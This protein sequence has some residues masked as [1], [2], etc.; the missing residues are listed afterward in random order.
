MKQTSLFL[1]IVIICFFT[2]L[3]LSNYAQI[4]N[5]GFES[6]SYPSPPS[7]WHA[8]TGLYGSVTQNSPGHDNSTNAVA[9]NLG[10]LT[11]ANGGVAML[12]VGTSTY[13]GF[14]IDYQRP[15][16]L[17]G[18]VKGSNLKATVKIYMQG[19]NTSTG[20]GL[21]GTGIWQSWMATGSDWCQFII[22]INYTTSDL[23]RIVTIELQNYGG[24]N[25]T[26]LV[27]DL[28]LNFG[29]ANIDEVPVDNQISIFPNP[30]KDHVTITFT[31]EINDTYNLYDNLGRILISNEFSGNEF[32][33]DLSGLSSGNYFVQIGQLRNPIK[34]IKE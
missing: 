6:W 15:T 18:Y 5:P 22:P 32:N 34:L 28:N 29:T 33:M 9:L 12:R 25:S 11:A 4:P 8:I 16:Y 23:G 21:I 31:E 17:T 27:D 10:N 2:Y 26:V 19:G 20:A 24:S 14:V 13:P 7:Q 30:A 3:P 1:R